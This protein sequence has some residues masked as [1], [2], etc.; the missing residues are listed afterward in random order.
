MNLGEPGGDTHEI[1]TDEN[2]EMC[3]PTL[4]ACANGSW[5]QDCS[6]RNSRRL[7]NNLINRII[8]PLVRSFLVVLVAHGYNK[9]SCC[10]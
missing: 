3:S 1:L 10:S 4:Q 9:E 8:V 6:Q 7:E 2:E 5:K